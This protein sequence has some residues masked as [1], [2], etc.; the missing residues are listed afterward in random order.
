MRTGHPC[1]PGETGEVF[2][3]GFLNFD[4]PLIRYRIGDR[5]KLSANQNTR[6]GRNMT[7]IEE[8]AG[9]IEDT[10]TGPDGRKLVRFHGVFVDL[11]NVIEGQ[12]IQ[13]ALDDFEI[14]VVCVN[15]LTPAE[16]QSIISQDELT[17]GTSASPDK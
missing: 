13:H 1:K 16:C 2:S 15:R 3:T 17:I 12:V 5:V 11:P 4:Q 9:R 6:C 7:V 14:K 8:I 10:I